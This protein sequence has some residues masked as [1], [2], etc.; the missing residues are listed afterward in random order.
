MKQ[1][2]QKAAD[3]YKAVCINDVRKLSEEK[4]ISMRD[5]QIA[6]LS[7]G[8]V[9]YR[10]I[11]NVRLFGIDGQIKLL[12]SKV[13]VIGCGGLGGTICELLT[14]LGVGN[15]VI[16]DPDVF[17]EHNLNRQLLCTEDDI[18]KPK[19][20]CA[21]K[22]IQSVNSAAVV[23]AIQSKA[24]EE[25]I[26]ELISGCSLCMDALD[27]I[28]TRLVLEK[29]CLDQQI[30]LIHGAIGDAQ[31]QVSAI[32]ENAVLENVYGQ[33]D[34]DTLAGSPAPTVTVCAALQTAEAVKIITGMGE[35]LN[36]DLLVGNWLYNDYVF[37]NIVGSDS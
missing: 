10:Y 30:P 9:P 33:Q 7:Q 26:D 23:I 20:A 1:N 24:T 2:F 28:Q 36:G 31:F 8:I 3:N 6:F 14:R 12:K 5:A 25:N 17:E 32:C 22:R 27:N 15:L 34:S 29:A 18:G 35:T 19:V 4:S 16:V 11:G 13:C 21:K 37:F